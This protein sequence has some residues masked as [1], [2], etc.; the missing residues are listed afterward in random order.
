[1][2]PLSFYLI[3]F[4]IA[5]L[6]AALFAYLET[7][8]TALRLFEVNQ[9]ESRIGG[10]KKLFA[11]WRSAPQRLL[12]TILIASNF[13][14]VLCT[15][16]ITEVMQQ[17]LGSELGLA[18]GVFC[19]TLIILLFGNI[20]PKSFARTGGSRLGAS[21]LGFVNLL[22]FLLAPL[23]TICTRLSDLLTRRSEASE[24]RPGVTEQEIEFLIDYS[25]QKGLIEADKSEMLQNVFGLGQTTVHSIMIPKHEMVMLE[26]DTSVEKAHELFSARRYSR[27]PL[28][29]GSVDN[30]VGFIYQK[31]LFALIYNQQQGTVR[32]CMR[33]V[34][35][36]PETKKINQLLR[37]FL[38]TR[39]HLAIAID[40]YGVV[41]GL[42]TL[43]DVLEE[44]VGEIRDEHEEVEHTVVP[45]DNGEFLI[46]GNA[47]LRKVEDVLAIEFSSDESV[48]LGGFLAEQLQRVPKKGDQVSWQ[49]YCFRVQQATSRRVQQV[50]VS[51]EQ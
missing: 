36:V 35:F 21:T 51:A 48:T 34:V 37:E 30:I 23:V 19:A 39:R 14:D 44:I 43:E 46:N 38:K 13:A 33:P 2:S 11:I 25:D 40:E 47:E 41:A 50:L 45:L 16:L 4:G 29:E 7:S 49:G 22:V 1:M 18:I 20:V 31:D 42:V 5:L 27:I 9:L 26:V 10:Y 6:C 28:F 3:G 15:V 32:D 17:A 24:Q 12:I 8:V